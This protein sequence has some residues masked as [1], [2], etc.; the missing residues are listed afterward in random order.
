MCLG[1]TETFPRNF[2]TICPR[3]ERFRNFGRV[4]TAQ[5]SQGNN[6]RNTHDCS[7]STDPP[8]C[9]D[10][11]EIAACLAR[12]KP[13]AWDMNQPKRKGVGF[14]STATLDYVCGLSLRHALLR[15]ATTGTVA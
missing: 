3:F 15:G 6:Q 2:P 13:I 1:F 7:L 10:F 12:Y 5:R 8:F 11:V 14:G 9:P 4:E